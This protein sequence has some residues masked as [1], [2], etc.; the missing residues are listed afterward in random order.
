MKIIK[1]KDELYTSPNTARVDKNGDWLPATPDAFEP[2]TLKERFL[3]WLG[4]HYT[5]SEINQ[6][7]CVVCLKKMKEN[8]LSC[9]EFCPAC[10]YYCSGKGGVM[11]IQKNTMPHSCGN[12]K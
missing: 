5:F 6:P 8:C 9:E 7:Y 2:E 12:T 10:G 3:H 4:F 1:V 11:C